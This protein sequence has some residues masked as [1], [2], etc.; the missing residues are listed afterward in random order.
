[1]V[2]YNE[3]EETWFQCDNMVLKIHLLEYK[4]LGCIR[5]TRTCK[6]KEEAVVWL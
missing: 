3:A 6:Q 2:N 5:K 4:L 1:M